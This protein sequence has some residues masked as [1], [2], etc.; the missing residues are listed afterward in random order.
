MEDSPCRKTTFHQVLRN[1]L[2]FKN[3]NAHYRVHKSPGTDPYS[4]PSQNSFESYLNINFLNQI[5]TGV[6]YKDNQ[7]NFY[8]EILEVYSENLM[9]HI[10]ILCEENT[11][12]L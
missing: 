7:L 9:K 11:D 4:K 6:Y 3:S 12:F 10:N 1:S 5:K 8:K 2:N